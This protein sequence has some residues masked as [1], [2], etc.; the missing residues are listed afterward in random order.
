MPCFCVYLHA[1]QLLLEGTLTNF[2]MTE[3]NSNSLRIK[4]CKDGLSM[5]SAKTEM[6]SC[7]RLL[8]S[9]NVNM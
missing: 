8:H 3:N 9:F 5:F 1:V 6:S 2:T 4:Q 7:L